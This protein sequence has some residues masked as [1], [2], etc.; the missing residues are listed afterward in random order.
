VERIRQPSWIRSV[1]SF[2]S[3]A[4]R[5]IADV[6]RRGRVGRQEELGVLERELERAIRAVALDRD[7]ARKHRCSRDCSGDR[8][9]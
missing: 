4:S 1:P 5:A 7:T 9:K 8:D 6:D 2:D 3:T